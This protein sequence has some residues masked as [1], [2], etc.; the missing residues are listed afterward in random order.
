MQFLCFD[1]VAPGCKPYDMPQLSNIIK[2]LDIGKHVL[3]H[4]M[5]QNDICWVQLDIGAYFVKSC[6][7]RPVQFLCFDI[8]P[9]GC[10]LRHAT[11]FKIS[12][13]I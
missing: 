9:V 8:V 3:S 10:K 12:V 4:G 11:A 1:I 13:W 7:S 2:C 6:N 5:N